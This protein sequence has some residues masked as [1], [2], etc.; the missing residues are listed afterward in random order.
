[1]TR[2][3]WL[4]CVLALA[5]IPSSLAGVEPIPAG[6]APAGITGS[7]GNAANGQRLFVKDTCYFCHGYAGQGG[8]DGARIA[9]TALSSQA[10]IRYLRRPFGAMPAFTA[11]VVSDQDVMDIHAY[12]KSLPVAL[13]AKDIPLL[14][15]LRDK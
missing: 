14:N 7:V 13:P 3:S 10:F 6:Q 8:R 12:L 2:F 11:K 9:A 4:A 5:L 15:Q 1:M